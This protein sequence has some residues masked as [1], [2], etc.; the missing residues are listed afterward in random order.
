MHSNSA[1]A[2]SACSKVE[3]LCENSI[4][5]LIVRIQMVSELARV[6]APN[7]QMTIFVARQQPHEKV[8]IALTCQIH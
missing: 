4:Y 1:V 7:R 3:Y 8:E 6:C 5:S 2:G